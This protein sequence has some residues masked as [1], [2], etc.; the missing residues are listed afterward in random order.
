MGDG[1][2]VYFD[3]YPGQNDKFFA[4]FNEFFQK[5]MAALV[6]NMTAS[7]RAYALNIVVSDDKL[8]ADGAFSYERMFQYIQMAE[9]PDMESGRIDQDRNVYKSNTNIEVHFLVLLGEPTTYAKKRLRWEIEASP[10]LQGNNRRVF[11]RK[12]IPVITYNGVKPVQLADDLVYFQD[13]FAGAGFWPVPIRKVGLGPQKVGPAPD[14]AGLGPKIY[15]ALNGDFRAA[16]SGTKGQICAF[17][18]P[19]RWL[20]RALFEVLLL[21]G[22]ISFGLYIWVCRVRSIGSAYVVYLL[23]GAIPTLLAGGALYGCDPDL[24][25]VRQSLIP[26]VILIAVPLLAALYVN[27]R[28]RVPQP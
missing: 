12:V 5:L 28:K 20:V 13:N 27:L 22:S 19:R 15:A 7:H 11:L 8:G 10:V 26:L 3:G 6:A 1:V 16:P 2:T 24:A 17:V 9:H 4:E 21:I 18:C 23:L 14:G 25:R